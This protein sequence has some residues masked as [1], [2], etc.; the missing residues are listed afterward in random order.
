[1]RVLYLSILTVMIGVAALGC[2]GASNPT[3]APMTPVSHSG[4]S[5]THNLWGLWQFIADPANGKL[6]VIPLRNVAM[7]VNVVP[8]L[9]PPAG[10]KLYIKNVTFDGLVCDVDVTLVHPFPGM[11]Q[12]TGFDVAGIFISI[13]NKAGFADGDLVMAGPGDT[14]M[15]NPDGYTRWWNPTEFPQNNTILR[16]KDGLMGTKHSIANYNSTLN[17]YKLFSNNLTKDQDILELGPENKVEFTAGSANTRHYKIDFQ[18]GVTFNYAVDACW[19]PPTGSAPYTIDEFPE[20]AWRPEAWAI[21]VTELENTLYNQ[22]GD[23]G[24][25]LKLLV[26]VWDHTKPANPG[27]YNKVIVESPGSFLPVE[28]STPIGGGEGYSTYQVEI[29]NATPK[30]SS[31][32]LLFTIESDV[33]GYQGLI[34]DRPVSAYFTR[35][36]KVSPT[37][38]QGNAP[39][40]IAKVDPLKKVKNRPF[41]FSDNGSYDP[42]GGSIVLYEWDWD[43]NGTFDESGANVTHSWSQPGIYKIQFRV[44]DDEGEKDI[45]DTPLEIEVLSPGK[46]TFVSIRHGNYEIYRMQGD[47]TNLVRLTTDADSDWEPTWSPD[48]KKIAWRRGGYGTANIFIM[49]EDGSNQQQ[50]T[51]NG[52]NFDPD[53]TPDGEWI[54]YWSWQGTGGGTTRLWKVKPDGTQQQQVS[55]FTT[56]GYVTDVSVS[57][58]GN[59]VAFEGG[60]SSPRNVYTV[61]PDGSGAVKLTSY[62]GWE[63]NPEW[64]FDGSKIIFTSD[65]TDGRFRAYSMNPDGSQ[66]TQLSFPDSGHNDF[67]ASFVWDDDNILLL[68]RFGGS[69]SA[70]E[71]CT[72]EFS[73]GQLTKLTND[74]FGDFDP[75]WHKND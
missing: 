27:V 66:I 7:H 12:Y 35:N 18:S 40:A 4:T 48:G 20:N 49:N 34:P 73:T 51:T 10:V 13:G 22:G 43:N 71:I 8:I 19:E 38:P 14:R 9:E 44:T 6:E 52:W 32:E 30:P 41:N 1:M 5:A 50:I 56:I 16:Y 74:S 67:E 64:K 59:K 37:K 57:P 29:L 63:S 25:K 31:I 2:S 46:V 60:P 33:I 39:V 47:G 75:D 23:A 54:Y 21:S 24:G 65:L 53:W 70:N 55:F 42:D 36:V 11:S 15:L 69:E 26:D 62:T 58:L 72:Y 3:A 17:A 28:V 61:N 68:R 45:L